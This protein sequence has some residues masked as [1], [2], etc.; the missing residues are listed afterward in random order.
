LYAA[1]DRRDTDLGEILMG[2]GSSGS[3]SSGNKDKQAAEHF[4]Y[5]FTRTIHF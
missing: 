2:R 3:G 4:L 1:V 5:V